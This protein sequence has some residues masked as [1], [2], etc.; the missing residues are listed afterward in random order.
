MSTTATF[1]DLLRNPNEVIDRLDK[2][3][4]VLT[5]RGRESLRLSKESSASQEYEMV[6]ALARMIPPPS[7]MTP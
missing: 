4:V 7:L 2:G 5:R 6:A 1:S 3:H